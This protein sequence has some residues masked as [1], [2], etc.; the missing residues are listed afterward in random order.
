MLTVQGLAFKYPSADNES[1]SD[2][3]FTV[4]SSEVVQ[5]AGGNGVGKTTALRLIAGFLDAQRSGRILFR[6][7]DLTRDRHERLM[8]IA[9]VDQNADRGVVGCINTEENLA[10]ASVGSHPSVWR[11]AL[12]IKTREHVKKVLERGAFVLDVP[13]RLAN[14]LSGGQRQVLNLLTLLAKKEI[15]EVILLD[16]P[17][18]NL[19]VGNTERCRKIIE[20]LHNDGAAIVIVSHT[21]VAGVP[22]NRVVALHGNDIEDAVVTV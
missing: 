21:P 5:L 11:R 2:L 1:L 13:W 6:G 20:T 16:E 9:Y 15:P 18:N 22:I 4:H 7:A 12:S 19:D 10:L 14:Q 8:Q 3:S 17:T